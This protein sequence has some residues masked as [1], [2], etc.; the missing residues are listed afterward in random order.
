[1][2]FKVHH[3]G[4]VLTAIVLFSAKL[5]HVMSNKFTCGNADAGADDVSISYFKVNDWH[6]HLTIINPFT[7]KHL[8]PV[9]LFHLLRCLLT[10]ASKRAAVLIWLITHQYR[11]FRTLR[12]WLRKMHLKT[13]NVHL[14]TI[15]SRWRQKRVGAVCCEEVVMNCFIGTVKVSPLMS[16]Q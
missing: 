11:R 8:T 14:V 16:D 5:P 4:Y 3:T 2:G 9:L 13:L 12:S 10:S 7:R 6:V 15:C 1:M